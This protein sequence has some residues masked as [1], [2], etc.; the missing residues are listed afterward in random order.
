MYARLYPCPEEEAII[1]IPAIIII[2]AEL[3]RINGWK[4]AETA[5][6]SSDTANHLIPGPVRGERKSIG[7][8]LQLS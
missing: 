5:L 3:E 2:L 4:L 1:M 7:V 6:L 8:S